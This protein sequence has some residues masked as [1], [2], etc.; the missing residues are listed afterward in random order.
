MATVQRP[1]G[2]ASETH[3]V[4][5][6]PPP[7]TGHNVFEANRPLVEALE[8]EGGGWARE[9]VSALGAR[10]GSPEVQELAR[11]ANE[12][13]PRL[14]THDRYGNRVD[15]VDFHPSWHELLGLAVEREIPSFAW[16]RPEPGAHVA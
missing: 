3:E 5:N 16:R 6:Q 9:H 4:F 7:L 10:D 13:P 8:R 14:R 1:A 12:N 2:S 15:E 11:L